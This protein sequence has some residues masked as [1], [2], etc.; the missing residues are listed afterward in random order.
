MLVGAPKEIKIDE[1]RVGL[2]PSTVA[3]LVARGHAVA[4][5]TRAGEGACRSE[6]RVVKTADS[7][8]NERHFI[9]HGR[10]GATTGFF[11]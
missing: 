5:E 9:P 8:D 4:I 2:I 3:D 10:M 6:K 11:S 7:R 1:F